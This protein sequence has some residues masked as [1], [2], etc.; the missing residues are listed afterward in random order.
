MAATHRTTVRGD[1]RL[2]GR[3]HV[4]VLVAASLVSIGVLAACCPSRSGSSSASRCSPGTSNAEP[5]PGPVQSVSRAR[6][7]GSI[8]VVFVPASIAMAV[9]GAALEWTRTADALWHYGYLSRAT[10]AGTPASPS[11]LPVGC[12]H[13]SR[14]HGAGA[15][16]RQ[17][18]RPAV[19]KHPRS[20]VVPSSRCRLHGSG[21]VRARDRTTRAP[22]RGTATRCAVPG[23]LHLGPR[24]GLA[25]ER[26]VRRR[27]GP[28]RRVR[29]PQVQP[30]RREPRVESA[31]GRDPWPTT[32]R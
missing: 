23:R 27:A 29:L 24:I 25:V 28:S 2:R 31:S 21:P 5:C 17:P 4:R 12:S 16:P 32:R 6:W 13:R 18:R 3:E 14:L 15:R 22:C 11:P 8:L 1:G 30:D 9:L 19:R 20:M 26:G 7:Y 10:G